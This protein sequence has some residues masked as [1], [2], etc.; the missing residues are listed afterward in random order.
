MLAYE[1]YTLGWDWLVVS[2]NKIFIHDI[3]NDFV[4]DKPITQCARALK[5]IGGLH[6]YCTNT[7]PMTHPQF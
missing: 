3:F 2:I 4:S 5:K 6:D 7:R 1:H